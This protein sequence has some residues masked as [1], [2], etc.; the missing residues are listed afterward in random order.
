MVPIEGLLTL[1]RRKWHPVRDQHGGRVGGRA[2]SYL[3][4]A[5]GNPDRL[6]MRA[7]TSAHSARMVVGFVSAFSMALAARWQGTAGGLD[8]TSCV[9]VAACSSGISFVCNRDRKDGEGGDITSA[10]SREQL[11]F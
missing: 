10:R 8:S 1:S 4:V 3:G 6:D 5:H 9:M 11:F 7:V 2:S